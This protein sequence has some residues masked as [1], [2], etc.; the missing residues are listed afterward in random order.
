MRSI[1]DGE[2]KTGIR[3]RIVLRFAR[4]MLDRLQ[5][6]ETALQN[7]PV[8]VGGTKRGEI[9]R[10]FLQGVTQL[11]HVEHRFR[12]IPQQFDQGIGQRWRDDIDHEISS[13]PPALQQSPRF[14]RRDRFPQRRA[15]YV[16]LLSQFPLGR[17]SFT[18]FENALQNQLLDLADD[19][20]GDFWRVDRF[21]LHDFVQ[22]LH[23][24]SSLLCHAALVFMSTETSLKT[25]RSQHR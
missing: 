20:I 7:F 8:G 4:A 16:Q 1:G 25:H 12:V 15:G 17:Q 9:S 18:R 21:E 19:G 10:D 23:S 13:T 24:I 6:G 2:M 14:Q 22:A 11:Q 5:R 3:Y